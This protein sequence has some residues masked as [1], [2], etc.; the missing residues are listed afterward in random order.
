M[1]LFSEEGG[2]P[3]V[4]GRFVPYSPQGMDEASTDAEASLISQ[5]MVISF[6]YY[7]ATD[8]SGEEIGWGE[9]G[10]AHV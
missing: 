2:S 9:I 10:R 4:W 5:D 8:A 3:G 7:G 6:Q 1:E